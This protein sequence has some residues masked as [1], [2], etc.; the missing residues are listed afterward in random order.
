MKVDE[1]IGNVFNVA[2]GEKE[3]REEFFLCVKNGFA[4]K[5]WGRGLIEKR[6]N[7]EMKDPHVLSL[8]L[9]LL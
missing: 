9:L 6:N 5:I 1:R 3:V 4:V 8:L 2:G 7:R